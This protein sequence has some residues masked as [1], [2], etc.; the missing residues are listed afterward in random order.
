MIYG[1]L[2]VSTCIINGGHK[3]VVYTTVYGVHKGRKYSLERRSATSSGFL[4]SINPLQ[5]GPVICHAPK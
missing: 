4:R 1:G 2:C 3:V 5:S